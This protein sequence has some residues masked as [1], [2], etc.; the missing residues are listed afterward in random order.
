MSSNTKMT[1]E[2]FFTKWKQG[3]D[4][5]TPIQQFKVQLFSYWIIFI[6][7]IL[8]IISCIITKTWWLMIILI[9]SFILT[10][11]QWLGVYQ[12]YRILQKIEKEV[13]SDGAEQTKTMESS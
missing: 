4:K 12:R 7:I 11:M 3:I 9:G 10:G 6:G 13:Y 8:G 5:V 1:H 2:G